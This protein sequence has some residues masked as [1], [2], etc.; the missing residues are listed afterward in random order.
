MF[1]L[2]ETLE[3][4][5]EYIHFIMIFTSNVR[6]VSAGEVFCSVSSILL[7]NETLLLGHGAAFGVL[8]EARDPSSGACRLCRRAGGSQTA[9]G[10]A[11]AALWPLGARSSSSKDGQEW[12]SL[13][14]STRTFKKIIGGKNNS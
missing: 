10:A 2:L 1:C 4:T 6:V 5:V 11:S 8:S 14:L 9:P 13:P 3:N 12:R 7:R